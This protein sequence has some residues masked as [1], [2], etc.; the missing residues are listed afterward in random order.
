MQRKLSPQRLIL[1][2]VITIF[3]SLTFSLLLAEVVLRIRVWF[4]ENKITSNVDYPSEFSPQRH[5]R[6]IPNAQYRHKELEYDYLWANNSL[7][8]RDRPRSAQKAP[9]NFRILFFGDSMVQGYG[10]PLEQSMV[11]LLEDSINQP[12]RSQQIEILNAGIFGYSPFLEYLYLKE[13]TPKVSPDLVMVGLF[14]GNDIGDDYFYIKESQKLANGEFIFREQNWPWDYRNEVLKKYQNSSK[15]QSEHPQNSLIDTIWRKFFMRSQIVKE[16]IQIKKQRKSLENAEQDLQERNNILA[17]YKDDIRVSLG[18]VNHPVG[19]KSK[20]LEYWQNTLLYLSKIY[21]YL[22][23]KQ[24]PMI[25]VVIPDADE[26]THQFNEPYE[27]ASQFAKSKGIPTIELLPKMRQYSSTEI[28]FPIDGH[29]NK[30]GNQIAT[31]IIDQELRQL[32]LIP[33]IP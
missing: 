27:I 21:E 11:Y 17:K 33:P 25:L 7:G 12:P 1:L 8:M 10:V 31:Q 18:L 16:I 23:E 30:L 22:K 24:I 2:Q 14:V 3:I 28:L 20:R 32:N 26:K 13:I 6:L 9:N 19:D 15:N 29:W 4:N 5:H